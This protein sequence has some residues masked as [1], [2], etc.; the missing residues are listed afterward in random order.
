MFR[1]LT[2][3]QLARTEERLLHPATVPVGIAIFM[4]GPK[5]EFFQRSQAQSPSPP[6][7]RYTR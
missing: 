5:S 6:K 7:I 3:E 4:E 2:P 1:A